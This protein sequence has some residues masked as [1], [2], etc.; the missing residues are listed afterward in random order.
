MRLEKETSVVYQTSK[1]GSQSV[2]EDD[3]VDKWPKRTHVISFYL[4]SICDQFYFSSDALNMNYYAI[5]NRF[6]KDKR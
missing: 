5:G 2:A 3:A 4:V 1:Y 6:I